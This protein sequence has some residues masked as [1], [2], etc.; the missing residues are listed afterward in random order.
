[1]TSTTTVPTFATARG[2]A[3]RVQSAGAPPAATPADAART[4][5]R[6]TAG[7]AHGEGA[8]L[9]SGRLE[10]SATRSAGTAARQRRPSPRATPE[11]ER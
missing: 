8:P 11:A 4:I 5:S 2:P 3:K 9:G 7:S 10:A 1:M 6:P